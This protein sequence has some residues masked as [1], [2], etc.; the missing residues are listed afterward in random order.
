MRFMLCALS[1]LAGSRQWYGCEAL[2][3]YPPYGF[4]RFYGSFHDTHRQKTGIEIFWDWAS[5]QDISRLDDFIAR[6]N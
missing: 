4:S 5:P 3:R 1:W 2:D 6:V